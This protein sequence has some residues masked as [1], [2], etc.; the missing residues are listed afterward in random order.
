[1]PVTSVGSFVDDCDSV[2]GDVEG[3]SVGGFDIVVVGDGV[4]ANMDR[5]GVGGFDIVVVGDGVVRDLEGE[6]D[7]YV[8]ASD[9]G[10][11]ES[12]SVGVGDGVSVPDM[13]DGRVLG[14]SVINLLGVNV[15]GGETDVAGHT[16]PE[17]PN[18]LSNSSS[19]C[20]S[21]VISS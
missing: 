12:V 2:D 8:V 9:D 5:E 6:G 13:L 17:I 21:R 7:S 1:M 14:V 11:A 3:K 19:F 4:E 18:D 16:L 15:G 20:K 10:A